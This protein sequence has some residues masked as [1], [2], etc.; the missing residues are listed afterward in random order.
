MGYEAH[1]AG[2][3]DR[4]LTGRWQGPAIRSIKRRSAA[5]IAER[6]AAVVAAVREVAP[7]E[8]VNGG[9]TGSIHTTAREPV[10]TEITAGSGFYAPTLFDRY[11]DFTLT[12]AAMFALPVV[13][14]PSAGVATLLG[15]GYHASG[16][17]GRDRL[18]EPYLPRGLRLDAARGRG[19]GADAGA[20]RGGRGA[21]DRRPRVPPARQGRRA[22]RALRPA[23]PRERRPG[24]GRGARRTAARAA[25]SSRGDAETPGRPSCFDGRHARAQPPR[26]PRSGSPRHT[27]GAR[28]PGA[29]RRRGR[30]APEAPER[31]GPHDRRPDARVAAR[32]AE[33]ARPARPP[34][35][36]VHP[37][38][39]VV[40][41]LL[42]VAR[43]V[44]H[45]A[46]RPQP[47][48][49]RQQA[50][51]RR[52]REARHEQLPPAL[53]PARRVSHDAP[54]QVPQRLR[55]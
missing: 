34:R 49:A 2:L 27:G 21:P 31:A 22:L 51:H 42:P 10:V 39:R 46:V 47:R 48:R 23:L 6:R 1:I 55:T 35:H 16:P 54:R 12:P 19:R 11:A 26:R 28:A 25:P 20:R 40:L 3:G 8:L 13:R 44:P 24:G 15:G 50:A 5:E 43:H 9:G 7:I 41:A 33:R 53:A 36:H 30:G 45:R 17:A 4:P 37:Q 18:P 38:L 29:R 52:L 14:R 32:D